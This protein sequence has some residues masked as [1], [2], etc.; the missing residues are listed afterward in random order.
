MIDLIFANKPFGLRY[1]AADQSWQ[2]IYEANLNT[3]SP[4]SLG[5]QGD[6]T[7]SQQDASWLLLFTTNNEYYTVTSRL[8]RYIFESDKQVRF[9]F[10]STNPIYDNT[11]GTVISDKINVLSINT[12]PDSVSAFTVD[13][14]WKVVKEYVGIDG[15]VDNKKIIISF[16]EDTDN[17]IIQDPE[18][19]LNIVAPTVSPLTKYIVQ[20][21]YSLTAGQEE[22]QYI[23]NSG[24]T[25]V[26]APTQSSVLPSLTT[27]PDGQY[28]YFADTKVVK[29]LA[30]STASLVPTLDYKV[31]V[32]R[33]NLK[34]QYTHS[35]DY[36]SRIDPG[37][38]NIMDVYILTKN[39]DIA[40]RQWL[41]NNSLTYPLP[42]SS[43]EL[44]NLI[45]PSLNLIKAMSDE[46]V[47]HPVSYKVLFGATADRD[48][49]ATFK[50]TKNVSSVVS[51]N[52]IK[53]RV[54]TALN[55]FFALDNWNF[56]DTFYFTELATYVM[57]QLT[58]DITNFVIV[59]A[60]TDLY[61]GSL[62]EISCP[63][64][65]IFVNGATVD[66][67]EIISGITGSN[68]RTV[69]GNAITTISSNQNTTSAN[70][71]ATN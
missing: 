25:V 45:A 3:S 70:Y 17:G 23:N 51:D 47:Y 20:Q 15:Y 21:R 42:P 30:L 13:Q 48:V 67:I 37:A 53:A 55:S 64:D 56:G 43:A 39:Y 14:P 5:N 61:F 46:I 41:S 34:F 66:N 52:D 22:Y 29:K 9:Y 69:T 33:S 50:V 44:Y 31:Y 68:I 8:V 36:N 4:F 38:S 24:N 7:N 59:P 63:S 1:N 11:T 12:Q 58:P 40:Y 26:I 49:Q 57:N 27:Y 32:G 35:A 71:G 54:V 10:D 62:F 28:F 19:F 16:T 18:T 60:Q 65:K 2:I 6:T